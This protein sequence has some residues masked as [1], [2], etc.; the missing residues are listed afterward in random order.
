AKLTDFGIARQLSGLSEQL[1]KTGAMVGTP[2]YAAP[3]QMAGGEAVGPG[4]DLYALGSTLYALLA[5]APPF[6]GQA[7][8]VVRAVLRDDPRPLRL[9]RGDVDRE[10][11][12][13]VHR[14]LEKDPAERYPSAEALEADLRAYLAGE[15][16]SATPPSLARR[17]RRWRRRHPLGAGLLLAAPLI[18]G[19][20]VA[21]FALRPRPEQQSV[22]AK[23]TKLILAEPAEGATIYGPKAALRGRVEGEGWVEV[24]L[25]G[26]R[27]TRVSPGERFELPIHLGQGDNVL[28]VRWRDARGEEGEE[29]RRVVRRSV[30]DW[31]ARMAPERRAPVPLPRGITFGEGRGIYVNRKDGME[32]VYVP[33]AKFRML[34]K[35]PGRVDLNRKPGDVPHDVTLTKGYF[36][37]RFEVTIA[38]LHR[39]CQATHGQVKRSIDFDVKGSGGLSEETTHVTREGAFLAEDRHPTFSVHFEAARE[40]CEWAGLRLPTEAEWEYAALGGRPQAYPWGNESPVGRANIM[41]NDDYPHLAPVGTFKDDCSPFGAYDMVGNLREWVDDR[42]HAFSGEPEVDPRRPAGPTDTRL[43]RGS[44]WAHQ[45]AGVTVTTREPWEPQSTYPTVGFRVARDA[46][47]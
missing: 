16:I 18:L 26:R 27:A 22:A 23:P 14:C 38:Q 5:G 9:E 47:D 19:A 7:L 35:L 1:T 39:F 10:L 6:E 45:A 29:V 44:N 46:R 32:L 30:P 8:Q 15:P 41:G 36:I 17:L 3:E 33:P 12:T 25:A 11:E 13:I 42:F 2:S 28:R 34:A 40:Y 43:A 20:L 31:Y 4:A 21:A 24:G 37:G